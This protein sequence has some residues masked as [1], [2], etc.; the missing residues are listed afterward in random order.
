MRMILP[1]NV[2][3]II[4]TLY[5]N[6]F[7]AYAVGGCVRDT[8]LGRVPQDWDITTSAKPE[9]V[10]AL[11]E[12][13]I[14]TGIEHG[15]VTVMLDHVGY[16]VTTYRIDGEYEDNRHPREVIFT[17]NLVEDLKR[18]DFTINA[19]AYN[20]EEG[21]IDIFSGAAD[22]EQKQVRCVGIAK[23]RFGEDALRMLRAVRF[24][25]QL[26]FEI[27]PE[28]AEAVKEL[29][30]TIE[31][32]SAER[33]QVEMVKL[34]T[35]AHPEEMRT[36]CE[37]GLTK[38]FLPEFDLMMETPQINKHHMYSVGE[39][40]IAAMQNIEPDKVLRIAM[41]LHDVAKPAC[42]TTDEEG[43]EHYHGH[44][45][46]GEKMARAILHRLKFDNKT[47]DACA[48]LI[49]YHD[50]RPAI[51][52]KSIRRAI[53]RIGVD[54]IPDLLKVK[55]ADCLGQSLY[56]REE[57]LKY[58]DDFEKTY[59]IILQKN[60]CVQKKDMA[61][62]GR[63]LIELGMAQGKELGRVLDELFNMIIEE[64]DLNTK[65]KLIELAHKIADP[66]I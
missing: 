41:L 62:N 66:L 33:I 35:S 30:P 45:E 16:E 63:D 64:P 15:T 53:S 56:K 6:G 23:D 40:T 49:R 24:A 8:I 51:T 43:Q 29:A 2:N 13:T 7:E 3:L 1:E 32:V 26:G 12:H 44:P 31:H 9:Q 34:L 37:L 47:I 58:I 59:E 65:E 11:F 17:S 5:D 22:L 48:K 54:V 52:E 55:R 60:Q 42:R 28:T 19:M 4:H 14:D 25:A 57:K 61:I 27:V 21:L 36:A 38:V 46:L 18:R 50:D 39:H 10:K 20:D